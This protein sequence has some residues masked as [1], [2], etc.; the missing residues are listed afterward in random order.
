MKKTVVSLGSTKEAALYFDKVAPIDVNRAL[1]G[2]TTNQ[3]QVYDNC[4]PY[5]NNDAVDGVFRSLIPDA[6][7]TTDISLDFMALQVA[8]SV[9]SLHKGDEDSFYKVLRPVNF[10]LSNRYGITLTYQDLRRRKEI[11]NNLRIILNNNLKRLGFDGAPTWI[12]EEFLSSNFIKAPIELR[13]AL[14]IRDLNLIDVSK[15]SWEQIIEFRKDQDS[16]KALRDLRLF[17]EENFDGKDLG[18][19]SD[20]LSQLTEEHSKTAKLWKF[21]TIQKTLS[22]TFSNEKI[23]IASAGGIAAAFGGASIPLAAAAASIVPL[24]SFAL[25]ISRAAIDA[26]KERVQRPTQFLTNLKRLGSR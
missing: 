2:V 26:Q 1:V 5:D 19:I 25:E 4:V 15:L 12:P 6:V 22:A 20:K 9:I 17:F 7:D 3:D 24:G 21:E 11:S 18:F 16:M 10:H 13:F 23:L 14:S 8:I